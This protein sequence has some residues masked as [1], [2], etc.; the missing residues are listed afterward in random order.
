MEDGDV[1]V[2]VAQLSSLRSLSIL[3]A[4]A[5]SHRLTRAVLSVLGSAGKV[6][7]RL[8]VRHV[9]SARNVL[10]GFGQLGLRARNLV[11]TS[12]VGGQQYHFKSWV[13]TP[14][15]VERVCKQELEEQRVLAAFG[16]REE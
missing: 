12:G 16:V 10:E 4:D 15:D 13:A 6:W 9:C 5:A 1:P 11:F 8:E 3:P 2:L 7:D 14:E